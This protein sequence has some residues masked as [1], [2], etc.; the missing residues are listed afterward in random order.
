[1]KYLFRRGSQISRTHGR[2][3]IL[4]SDLAETFHL[5]RANERYQNIDL[6]IPYT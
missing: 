5:N 6:S 4:S 2:S 1:M 3:D